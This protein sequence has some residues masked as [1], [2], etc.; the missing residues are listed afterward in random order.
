[1]QIMEMPRLRAYLQGAEVTSDA[2]R[3]RTDVT[4]TARRREIRI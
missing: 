3:D 4:P 1:M 2:F